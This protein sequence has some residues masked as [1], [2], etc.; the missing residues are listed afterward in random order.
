MNT[1]NTKDFVLLGWFL[2][3]MFVFFNEQQYS[4]IVFERFEKKNIFYNFNV[5]Q[6]GIFGGFQ[7]FEVL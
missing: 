4:L 6:V 7:L 3:Y 5:H 2:I 1:K